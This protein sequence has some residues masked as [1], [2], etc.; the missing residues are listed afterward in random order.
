[1]TD[2]QCLWSITKSLWFENF[3]IRLKTMFSVV[4][5]DHRCG[6]SLWIKKSL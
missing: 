3:Y 1:M 5:N 4:T 2:V 6:E